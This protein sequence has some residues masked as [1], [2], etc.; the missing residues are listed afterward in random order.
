MNDEQQPANPANESPATQPVEPQPVEQT[1]SANPPKRRRYTIALLLSLLLGP[2]G[3]DRYYL[4][5]Y[6]IGTL[7][8][9][10]FGF[11]GLWWLIDLF[12][13]LIF[14]LTDINGNRLK[15]P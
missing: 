3:V 10:T 9:L 7:K 14:K 15:F 6:G 11:F 1:Q 12:L 4:G 2:L 5:Y 8:L 13:I